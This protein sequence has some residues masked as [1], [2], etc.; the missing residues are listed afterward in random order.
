MAKEVEILFASLPSSEERAGPPT[1]PLVGALTL[2]NNGRPFSEEDWSRLRKIAEG[3]PDE[4]KVRATHGGRVSSNISIGR[5]LWR[6]F[7]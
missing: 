2:R 3:N 4:Q 6:R 5:L 1:Q 7:L